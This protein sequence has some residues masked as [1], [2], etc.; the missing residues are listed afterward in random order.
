MGT[1]ALWWMAAI[2][3]VV[4]LVWWIGGRDWRFGV[5]IVAA[6]STYI[7][8]FFNADRPVFFFYTICIVPFTVTLLAMA[9]GLILGPKNGPNRRRGAIIVGVAIALVALDFAYIYP[10]LTDAMLLD[11]DYYSRMWL[12]SWI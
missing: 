6:M 3:L 7:F 8:W 11:N 2:A 10:V 4:A 9:L 5:P 12:L 1:P